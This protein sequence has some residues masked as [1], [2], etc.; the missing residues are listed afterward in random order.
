[1]AEGETEGEKHR[2]SVLQS[3]ETAAESARGGS[4][5]RLLWRGNCI[6]KDLLLQV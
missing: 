1:M 4:P 5:G 2:L 3:K 6:A